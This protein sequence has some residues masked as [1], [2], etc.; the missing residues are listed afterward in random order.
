MSGPTHR[1]NHTLDLLITRENSS[2]IK[3]INVF[4]AWLSDHCLIQ[5]SINTV[6]VKS[7]VKTVAYR[8]WNDVN[9]DVLRHDD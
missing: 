5:A 2:I 6:K 4:P 7:A 9:A 3:D 8:N 1:S